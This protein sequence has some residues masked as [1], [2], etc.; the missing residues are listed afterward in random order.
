M[1][2]PLDVRL[3]GGGFA[4]DTR[5]QT[6]IACGVPTATAFALQPKAV[7][8]APPLAAAR[9]S[10]P[11]TARAGTTVTYAVRIVS[12]SRGRLALAA[13]PSFQARL[14]GTDVNVRASGTLTCPAKFLSPGSAL[15][16]HE[17]LVIPS[18]AHGT[19]KLI[20]VSSTF[21]GLAA[22]EP[23]TITG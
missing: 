15:V 5:W 2:G 12:L 3:P 14:F 21:G 6:P 10:A 7:A 22:G 11:A 9:L 1:L 23:I 19:I 17:H 4:T 20:W 8:A 16:I 13:C 18:S